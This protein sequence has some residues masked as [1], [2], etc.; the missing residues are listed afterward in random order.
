M[1]NLKIWLPVGLLVI[2]IIVFL[3]GL[4]NDPKLIP[5]VLIGKKAPVFKLK[6]LRKDGN[7]SQKA[8]SSDSLNGKPWLLNVF[9]SWCVTCKIE[10]KYFMEIAKSNPE[11]MLVG[12]A[13]KDEPAATAK[14]LKRFGNPYGIVVIDKEGLTGIDWGVYGVPET[15]VVNHDGVIVSKKIGAIDE[16]FFKSDAKPLLVKN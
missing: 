16:N 7:V 12:L 1:K 15:F 4:Q 5:S 9:A 10:H 13:Y 2:L 6:V 3:M 14:W 8:F 11:F